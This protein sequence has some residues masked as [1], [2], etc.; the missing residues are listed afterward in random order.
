LEALLGP[1][2]PGLS[3]TTISR[4]KQVWQHELDDW[5]TRD[6]SEKRYGYFWVDAVHFEARMET[7][8]QCIVVI[9]GANTKGD[10]ALVGIWDGYA[11]SEQS[12]NE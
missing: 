1:Q 3:P 9:M 10:K 4:L 5:Q 8:H 2:A 7:A 6:V 11:E 12:W